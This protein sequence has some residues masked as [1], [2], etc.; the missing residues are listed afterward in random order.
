MGTVWVPSGEV[1]P[2][3]PE[4]TPSIKSV[5]GARTASSG[6]ASVSASGSGFVAGG[7]LF[8]PAPE[9]LLLPDSLVLVVV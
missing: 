8:V 2:E 4:S 6:P 3:R 1:A 9:S 5:T 7:G